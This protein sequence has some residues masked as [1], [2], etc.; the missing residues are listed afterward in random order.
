MHVE[1]MLQRPGHTDLAGRCSAQPQRT[2]GKAYSYADSRVALR[3]DAFCCRADAPK[4]YAIQRGPFF[5]GLLRVFGFASGDGVCA[6]A[7]LHDTYLEHCPCHVGHSLSS[8][9][10]NLRRLLA[11]VNAGWRA[12]VAR[13]VRR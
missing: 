5:A 2:L 13:G 4:E 3:C 11:K 10:W 12:V 8:V 9:Y 6:G 7:H 1:W